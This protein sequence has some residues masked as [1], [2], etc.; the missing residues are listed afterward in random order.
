MAHIPFFY[1]FD[2][3]KLSKEDTIHFKKVLKKKEG[4]GLLICNGEGSIFYAEAIGFKKDNLYFEIKELKEKKEKPAISMAFAIPKG[5]RASFLIEKITELGISE[6]V[7]IIS[8]YSS[9]R[10]IT[11]GMLKRYSSIAKA[12]SMQSEKG[13]LPE[14]KKPLNLKDFLKEYSGIGI[15]HKNGKME[16]W[17][18]FLKNG[19]II[20]VGPE[21]GWADEE[22]ELFKEK[23]LPLLPL[24]EDPLRVETAAIVG[25][26]FYYA[27]KFFSH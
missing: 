26:S 12:A 18:N 10:N 23:N 9:V 25:L 13:F 16:N 6:I 20:L 15:L 4:D 1:S 14:I 19:K 24:T 2:L 3:E 7:P 17:K 5:Y 21:G 22:I 27:L 8:K 11:E